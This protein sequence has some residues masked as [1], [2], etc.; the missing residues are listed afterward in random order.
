MS[1]TTRRRVRRTAEAM[2]YR[3]LAQAQGMRTGRTRTLG[4]VRQTDAKGAQW[5]FLSDFL[6]GITRAV[7]A[8]F[9]TLTV[10]TSA[11]GEE[12]LSTLRRLVEER[13]SD[14]NELKT[15]RTRAISA[16]TQELQ[17]TVQKIAR[18]HG[19]TVSEV[20]GK[21]RKSSKSAGPA[22][23]RNPND[24]SQTWPGCGRQPAWFSEAMDRSVE[25]LKICIRETG[26]IV[27][28]PFGLGTKV[29]ASSRPIPRFCQARQPD[30]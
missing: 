5:P 17:D 20:L 1:E 27:C 3:P 2:G 25:S 28:R 16:A 11:G 8:E 19:L 18:K 30:S 13:K 6:A 9:W 22:K 7:S 15:S 21:K 23:Y 12:M 14:E 24:P 10:A 26:N 4:L 29:S